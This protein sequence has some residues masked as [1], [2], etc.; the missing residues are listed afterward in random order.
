MVTPTATLQQAPPALSTNNHRRFNIP[1]D[2]IKR[3]IEDLPTEQSETIWWFAQWCRKNDL[4]RPELGTVLKKPGGGGFYSHD[5]IVQLFT[6]GRIRRGE[7]I[8]PLLDAI[9]NLRKV[10]D[11]RSNQVT[12]GFIE[13]RL[14]REIEKRCLKALHRQRIGFIFGDSQIGKTASL[15]EVERRHNH[16]QTIYEEIPVG[17]GVGGLIYLLAKRNGIPCKVGNRASLRERVIESFDSRMLLI[18]DEAH[19]CLRT[20]SIAGLEVFSFLRE[21]WNRR[22]CGM[23]LSFTNEGRDQFLHG[24]H[25]AQLAQ[26]WRRRITPLQLPNVPPDDDAALFAAAYGLPEALDE[27]VTIAVTYTD[28]NGH[29]Q[30]SKHTASPLALQRQVLKSEG[31]GVWI[32]ILQDAADMAQEQNKPITWGA[33]IKAQC[34]SVSDAQMLD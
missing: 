29:H 21:L 16:G 32:G 17:G 23:V 9:I 8:D 34:Q 18:L 13:T 26:M 19:R 6:G 14:F 15:L 4:S 5:S 24:P 11:Q 31:L 28:E 25:A 10:E 33:V 3:A 27:P 7:N 1:G 12:S 30:S 2:Q 22:K 20:G